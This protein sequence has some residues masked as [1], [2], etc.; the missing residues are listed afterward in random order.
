MRA[1]KNSSPKRELSLFPKITTKDSHTSLPRSCSHN[2]P[3]NPRNK[4]QTIPKRK[5][6]SR[7]KGLSNS[8]LDQ[9]D[10]LQAPSGPPARPRR[11]VRGAAAD[12]LIITP[13]TSS[14]APSITDCLRW[15]RRPSAPSRTVSHSRTERPRTPCNKNPPTKWIE[16]KTRKNSRK[17]RRTLGLSGSSRTVHH[18]P[19]DRLPGG[20][21][22]PEPNLLEV[23][24]SSPLPDLPNQPMD[25]DQIIGEGEAPLGDAMPTNL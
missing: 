11:I 13:R 24:P 1:D 10:R 21:L 9:V 2:G 8:A 25:C 5:R 4:P 20:F 23:K 16:R 22:Q 3:T 14:T 15:A 12:R 18:A 19:M 17:T 6:N 7:S